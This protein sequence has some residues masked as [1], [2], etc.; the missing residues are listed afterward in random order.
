MKSRALN[1]IGSYHSDLSLPFKNLKTKQSSDIVL[2]GFV[3]KEQ[4]LNLS[5][6]EL[7]ANKVHIYSLIWS[8]TQKAYLLKVNL[9]DHNRVQRIL[10]TIQ[11]Q[12]VSTYN[13]AVW[14]AGNVGSK[15]IDIILES[16][17]TFITNKEVRFNIFAVANSKQVLLNKN[18][19][20]KN[21]RHKL[22]RGV[23]SASSLDLLFA[24]SKH[25][26]FENLIFVDASA[27]QSLA[28]SY[29]DIIQAGYDIVAANKIANTNK[30]SQYDELQEI[31][32]QTG[33]S[34]KFE[35]NVG[36]ALP[37]IQ[38]IHQIQDS[39]DRIRRIRGTFSGSLNYIFTQIQSGFSFSE[40]VRS[41]REKGF[42]EPDPRED[43]SGNDVAR[44]LLILA[45]LLGQ[46]L[47]LEDISI[48]SLFPER[49]KDLSLDEFM[50]VLGDLDKPVKQ[51]FNRAASDEALVYSADIILDQ[52]RPSQ[53]RVGV[54]T[55]DKRSVLANL[56]GTDTGFEIF[57]EAYGERPICISGAG[58]GVELTA[59]GLLSDI[60]ALV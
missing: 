34:F 29:A 59:R 25:F 17:D 23:E 53:I 35:T 40:S 27:S 2:S 22:K 48:E 24:Y 50:D 57:T 43:L 39:G 37:I 14:G 33:Q 5:L 16:G 13:I 15:L 26:E 7:L 54:Q 21:W 11:D 28:D 51:I 42:T 12:Q 58:A 38:T 18:G 60:F 46:K 6:Q 47:N 56:S 44:K 31:L 10:E 49:F 32:S 41:A 3:I 8:N 45:R 4:N 9:D 19:V 30:Q 52:N 55:L 1:S 20:S 36:A